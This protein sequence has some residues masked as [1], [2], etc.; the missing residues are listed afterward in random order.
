MHRGL[1]LSLIAIALFGCDQVRHNGRTVGSWLVD[2]D[3]KEDFKRRDALAAVSAVSAAAEEPIQEIDEVIPQIIE[4]LDDTNPGVQEYARDALVSL[5]ARAEPALREAAK[6][7]KPHVKLH[8]AVALLKRNPKDREA[9]KIVAD[10]MAGVG[11]A[12]LAAM[13]REQMIKLGA[14]AV[15]L[16]RNKLADP[17][18]PARLQTIKTIAELG[19]AGAPL[20]KDLK[21]FLK[22]EDGE[23]RLA[24]LRALAG[25]GKKEDL[26]PLFEKLRK[27][28]SDDELATHAAVMLKNIGARDSAS[29]Y[30]GETQEQ[31]QK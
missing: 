3:S 14:D 10:T 5:G 26:V 24:A 27:D 16:L 30:E 13:G 21:V 4:L 12:E 22:D 29:G 11:N 31:A 8:A 1:I 15:P 28:E 25:V 6:S 17:Y 7:P 2:L 20:E 18:K 9:G 19:Q 23:L